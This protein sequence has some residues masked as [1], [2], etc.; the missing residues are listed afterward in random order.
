[1]RETSIPQNP[2]YNINQVENSSQ[3]LA[4][5]TIKYIFY[6]YFFGLVLAAFVMIIEMIVTKLSESVLKF[7]K[8]VSKNFSSIL[9][10]SQKF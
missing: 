2:T 8:F 5:D 3:G 7:Q 1:M 10:V 9:T 4:L 6:L